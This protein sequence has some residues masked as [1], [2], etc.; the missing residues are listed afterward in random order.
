ME[1]LWKGPGDGLAVEGGPGM[2][3]VRFFVEQFSGRLS[4]LFDRFDLDENQLSSLPDCIGRLTKLTRY[5]I[6]C[7][8]D[9]NSHRS[10]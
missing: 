1:A 8:I 6:R 3:K 4:S 2:R 7:V 9:F 10:L 5:G